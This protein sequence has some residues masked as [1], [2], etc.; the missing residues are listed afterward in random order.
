LWSVIIRLFNRN[1][2]KRR[3][4]QALVFMAFPVSIGTF[5]IYGA[6]ALFSFIGEFKYTFYLATIMLLVIGIIWLLSADKLIYKCQVEKNE[7]DGEEKLS[8]ENK[9]NK[10]K[11]KIDSGFYVLFGVLAFFAIAN[12]FVKDGL[13]TWTPTIF[14]DKF[15]LEN[16]F[17]VLLTILLPLFAIL[18]ANFAITLSKKVKNY[19]VSCGIMYAMS[20]VVLVALILL[21]NVN[22]WVVTLICFM[23]VSAVMAGIN[24]VITNIFPLQV[25]NGIDAGLVAGLIDGFCY[26]GSAIASF[27][28]GT[29]A[30]SLCWDIIMYIF[31]SICALCVLT[32]ICNFLIQK[33]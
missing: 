4:K 6:S 31:T 12:N 28:L 24:N 21:L 29:I 13:N 23:L 16:W 5:C 10:E 1:L 22:S 25:K 27:G 14:T 30:E 18:G 3:I 11:V 26:V 32:V 9:C 19:V 33:V 8:T 17:A 7:V 2:S 15:H 20:T